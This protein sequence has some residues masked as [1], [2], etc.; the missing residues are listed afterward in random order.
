MAEDRSQV[1]YEALKAPIG[2]RAKIDT[3]VLVASMI[4][5][6]LY[7]PKSAA[8]SMFS[9]V[10]QPKRYGVMKSRLYAFASSHHLPRCRDGEVA[11]IPAWYGRTWKEILGKY[12]VARGG[13]AVELLL[14]LAQIHE[15]RRLEQ[16]GT[17]Q[18]VLV[19]RLPEATPP[20]RGWFLPV[21]ALLMVGLVGWL[22]WQRNRLA[23]QVVGL[24]QLSQ[25]RGQSEFP[26]L[27]G[28]GQTPIPQLAVL[29]VRPLFGEHPSP[30]PE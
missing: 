13:L 10:N 29:P 2:P 28:G 8:A 16:R 14:Q 23:E 30:W 6:Q 9:R 4:D 22:S 17:G 20:R 11:G 24:P 18:L 19:P 7:S 26:D 5:D 12:E 25:Q 1:V 15:H 3:A 21:A 27:E